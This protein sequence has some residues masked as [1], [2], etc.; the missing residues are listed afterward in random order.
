MQSASSRGYVL[1]MPLLQQ[2][3]TINITMWL[4]NDV[5]GVWLAVFYPH[6]GPAAFIDP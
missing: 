3:H 5:G 1:A 2:T 4:Q 6:E